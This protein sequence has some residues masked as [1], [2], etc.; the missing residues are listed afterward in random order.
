MPHFFIVSVSY[1]QT[2]FFATEL[3]RRIADERLQSI[4][5]SHMRS[6]E[7]G[8]KNWFMKLLRH[9]SGHCF[10][11]GYHFSDTDEWQNLF[12]DPSQEYSPDHYT[13]NK[14]SKEFVANLGSGYGQ[15]HPDEDFSET[16]AV[17]LNPK[18]NW[19]FH[20]RSKPIA[21]KKLMYVESLI[22]QYGQDIPTN[23]ERSEM[24]A[25][26]KM[27]QTLHRYYLQRKKP[28]KALSD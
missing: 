27:R 23:I 20:Y 12:G 8:T 16:F 4:E 28:S 3:S 10:D 2:S 17:V 14:S 1:W 5:R 13:H 11:H 15:A 9:E 22:R 19:R 6:V 26:R 25:A 18:S 24:C 21:L 7:G